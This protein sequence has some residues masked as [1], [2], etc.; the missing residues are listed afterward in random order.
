MGRADRS[1]PSRV[2]VGYP[3]VTLRVRFEGPSLGARFS[4]TTG[5][6]RLAVLVDGAPPRVVRLASGDSELLLADGLGPGPHV[7]DVVHRTETWQGIVTVRGFFAG[8]G[9][10]ILPPIPGAGPSAACCS[11]ATP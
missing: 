11:S 5:A 2:R 9:G 3:G 10:K 1:D 4:C 6:S 7:V 8:K